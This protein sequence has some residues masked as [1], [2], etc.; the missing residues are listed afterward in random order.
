MASMLN[1]FRNGAVGFIDWLDL[2]HDN[3]TVLLWRKIQ[4]TLALRIGR[5][6]R[7][8]TNLLWELER[9]IAIGISIPAVHD[10]LQSPVVH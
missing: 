4:F 3:D 10:A 9:E 7:D 6:S 8:V 1:L 5:P 2:S